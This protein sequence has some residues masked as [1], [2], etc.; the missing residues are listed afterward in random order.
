MNIKKV[1]KFFSEVKKDLNDVQIIISQAKTPR[2]NKKVI[3]LR[4]KD[5][6]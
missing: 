1:L 4:W 3:D 5:Y 2:L 6:I